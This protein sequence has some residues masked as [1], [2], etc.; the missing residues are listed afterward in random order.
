MTMSPSTTATV[1]G[2]RWMLCTGRILSFF[3]VLVLLSGAFVR[4]TN[5]TAAVAEI[6]TGYGYPESAIRLIVIAEC[7]LVVLIGVK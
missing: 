3:R 4:A 6:V 1:S 2:P 5:H 7:A